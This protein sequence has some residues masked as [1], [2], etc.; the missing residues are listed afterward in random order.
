MKVLAIIPAYNEE[1]SLPGL[2]RQTQNYVDHILVI[3]DGSSDDTAK[4]SLAAGAN[5]IQHPRNLG[6][7]AACRS[8]FYA[9]KTLNVD[10]VIILDS[11]GQHDPSDIPNFI[12]AFYASQ[13]NLG[14]IIGNRMKQT[15]NMPRLRYFTNLF[16]SKLISQL[17]GQKI[18]DSQCGFRL[19]HKKMLATIDFESNRFDAESEIIVRAARSGFKISSCQ[20]KTIYRNQYSKISP[21]RD[22]F[23]FF[24]FY[25][26]HFI[27]SPPIKQS[28]ERDLSVQL[29]QK[30]NNSA[31]SEVT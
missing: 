10:A 2:I 5:L 6:K 15:H 30:F 8:G 27:S 23:R 29:G 13:C 19:I 9:A 21:I 1:Q 22:T 16:L 25:F 28:L 18:S 11:D 26:R 20:I 24:K 12:Q 4:V 17:A 3:D 14:M 7:G 31:Y